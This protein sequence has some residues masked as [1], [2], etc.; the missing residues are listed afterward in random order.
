MTWDAYYKND[1]IN[2]WLDDLVESY[3][4]IVTSLDAGP[5]YEGRPIKGIKISH[6]AG[7]RIIFLEA[8]I[9]SREWIS[10]ATTCYIANEL[11]TSEDPDVQKYAREYDWYIFPVTNPDGYIWS[12]DSVSYCY[13][14]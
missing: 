13:F 1:E 6:G 12:H 10:P 9:H 11:L 14:Y 5:S 8:G 7:R 4:D 3:P 2:S